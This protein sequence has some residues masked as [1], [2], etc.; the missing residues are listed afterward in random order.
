MNKLINV[1]YIYKKDT[2]MKIQSKKVKGCLI[3]IY[4]KKDFEAKGQQSK[5]NKLTISSQSFRSNQS[6]KT[7]AVNSIRSMVWED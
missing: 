4:E 1:L 3:R 6:C 7:A 2:V 5:S